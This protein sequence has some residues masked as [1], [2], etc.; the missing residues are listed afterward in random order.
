[1]RI[2]IMLL[3]FFL[4]L[5]LFCFC[6]YS[7]TLRDTWVF[8][9]NLTDPTPLQPLTLIEGATYTLQWSTMY[10]VYDLAILMDT[11]YEEQVLASFGNQQC[12]PLLLIQWLYTTWLLS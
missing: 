10:Y 2:R 12:Y 8:P 3:P 9:P 11:T 6:A 1:M 5:V 7:Q 4:S